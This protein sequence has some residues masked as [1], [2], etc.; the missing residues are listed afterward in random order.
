MTLQGSEAVA[1]VA[2]GA[3][4]TS[5]AAALTKFFFTSVFPEW[6]SSLDANIWSE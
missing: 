5:A 2:M 1:L 6:A 3:K 4:S